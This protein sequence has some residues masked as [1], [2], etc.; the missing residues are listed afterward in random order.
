MVLGLKPFDMILKAV[1]V[2]YFLKKGDSGYKFRFILKVFFFMK[3]FC[4][5]YNEELFLG[6]NLSY[7]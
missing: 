1:E 6:F 2:F 3:L 5:G 4:G 7:T